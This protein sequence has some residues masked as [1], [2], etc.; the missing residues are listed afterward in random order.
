MR[1]VFIF[2]VGV[3]LLADMASAKTVTFGLGQQYGWTNEVFSTLANVQSTNISTYDATDGWLTLAYNAPTNTKVFTNQT[4]WTESNAGGGDTLLRGTVIYQKSGTGYTDQYNA[5]FGAVDT[6]YALTALAA[7]RTPSPNTGTT[8]S[9]LTFYNANGTHLTRMDARSDGTNIDLYINDNAGNMIK[10]DTT[11]PA[12]SRWHLFGFY[13]P[14]GAADKVVATVDGIR[15]ATNAQTYAYAGLGGQVAL[16]SYP[17]GTTQADHFVRQIDYFNYPLQWVGGIATLET[18]PT[19]SQF[20]ADPGYLWGRVQYAIVTGSGATVTVEARTSS[21]AAGVTA[22]SYLP[23]AKSGDLTLKRGDYIQVRVQM[24]TTTDTPVL[25]S[26][27]LATIPK[28]FASMG[29]KFS[30]KKTMIRS[31]NK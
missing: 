25:Q 15:F 30:T 19:K 1:K 23:V 4:G 24:T 10:Y 21:T 13:N 27:S 7:L 14:T 6:T 29:N 26:L 2:L 9:G 12:D 8:T 5:T 20:K 31:G 16:D 18:D 22:E 28:P 11:I 17:D 3:L